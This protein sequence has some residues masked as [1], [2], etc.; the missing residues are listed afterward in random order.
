MEIR[1][2]EAPL[3]L[4]SL[5]SRYGP[6]ML[7]SL[8]VFAH[9]SR[10]VAKKTGGIQVIQADLREIVGLVPEHHNKVNVAIKQVK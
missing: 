1:K 10:P 8:G 7:K 5:T 4:A 2:Q 9:L 3:L 6:W